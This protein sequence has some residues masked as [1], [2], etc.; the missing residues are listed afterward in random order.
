[1]LQIHADIEWSAIQAGHV[2]MRGKDSGTKN[3]NSKHK[4]SLE[5]RVI[6]GGTQEI[7]SRL[8]C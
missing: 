2:V 4:E 5:Q 6:A 8:L 3:K 7:I 1:M